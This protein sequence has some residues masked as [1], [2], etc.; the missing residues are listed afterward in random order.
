M[1]IAVRYQSRGGNTKMVAEA[2]AKAAGVTAEPVDVPLNEPVD[3]LFV[4]GGVY[5]FSMDGAL[6][7]FVDALDLNTVKSAAAFSTGGFVSIAGKIASRIKSAGVPVSKD[8]LCLKLGGGKE[9]SL[10]DKHLEKIDEFVKAV[11]MRKE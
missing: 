6:K 9:K 11:Q 1:S 2:I 10:S 4:G 8:T 3:L 7:T 5:A